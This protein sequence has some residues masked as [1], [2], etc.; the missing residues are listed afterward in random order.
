MPALELSPSLALHGFC[1]M[2]PFVCSSFA[3]RVRIIEGTRLEDSDRL[4]LVGADGERDEEENPNVTPTLASSAFDS[5]ASVEPCKSYTLDSQEY[6][7]NCCPRRTY[8]H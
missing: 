7:D 5:D 1:R 6:S 2:V 3:Q 8:D 4:R